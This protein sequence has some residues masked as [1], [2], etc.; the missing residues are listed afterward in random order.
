[1]LRMINSAEGERLTA[2]EKAGAYQRLRN[3]GMTVEEIATARGQSALQISKV[4]KLATAPLRVKQ[5]VREGLM[6]ATAAIDILIDC[7]KTGADA[8]ATVDQALAT[9]A[10]SGKVRATAKHVKSGSGSKTKPLPRKHVESAIGTLLNSNF[11]DQLRSALPADD[12]EGESG[13]VAVKIPASM[14]RD[15]LAALEE[16]YKAKAAQTDTEEASA[17]DTQQ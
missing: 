5:V 6:S 10:S 11:A 14:G 16:L 7:E 1:M 8:S 9:A 12:A 15:L 13:D 2:L 3:Q 4:L 17:G